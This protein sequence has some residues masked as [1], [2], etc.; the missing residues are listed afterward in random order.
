M[1]GFSSWK[2]ETNAWRLGESRIEIEERFTF[3]VPNQH[4][5]LSSFRSVNPSVLFIS[6]HFI[7]RVIKTL[8]VVIII[9]DRYYLKLLIIS[10][11]VYFIKIQNDTLIIYDMSHKK[12]FEIN[13]FHLFIREN[14]LKKKKNKENN[15]V[16][17]PN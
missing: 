8:S 12:I 16:T 10:S 17:I 6:F 15:K 3:T 9:Y 4:A 2:R 11:I 14:F 1:N 13:R 7:L 5:L